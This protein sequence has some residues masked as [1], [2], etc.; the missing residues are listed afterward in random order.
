M[1]SPHAT[2]SQPVGLLPPKIYESIGKDALS[3][4]TNLYG[5][6]IQDAER[7]QETLLAFF[8]RRID[9]DVK[10]LCSLTRCSSPGAF[11]DIEGQMWGDMVTDY[12]DLMQGGLCWFGDTL[13]HYVD[14][15][16]KASGWP[17]PWL[18]SFA[19]TSREMS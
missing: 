2:Q 7:L 3:F 13:Q 19:N 17:T 16:G 5:A 11:V 8:D 6:W 4:G 10:T 9:K 1:K 12:A 18:T 14:E 15:A